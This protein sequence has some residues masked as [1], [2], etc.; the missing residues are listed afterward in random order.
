MMGL[1]IAFVS[2]FF[3][4]EDCFSALL[5]SWSWA[6]GFDMLLDR[7]DFPGCAGALGVVGP[8]AACHPQP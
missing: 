2:Q 6:H 5:R 3:H 8:L 1:G 4:S 7:V